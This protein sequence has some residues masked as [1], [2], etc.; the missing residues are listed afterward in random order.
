MTTFRHA[1]NG[2]MWSYGLPL[3]LP[4]LRSCSPRTALRVRYWS[5]SRALACERWIQIS[6][7]QLW[8][9]CRMPRTSRLISKAPWPRICHSPSVF[10]GLMNPHT[11]AHSPGTPPGHHNGVGPCGIGR[12]VLANASSVVLS[13]CWSSPLLFRNAAPLKS[14]API[15][16]C[17]GHITVR[18]ANNTFS[19]FRVSWHNGC[20]C[21]ATS[22]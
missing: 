3:F 22:W 1:V 19:R 12:L 16:T 6:W 15:S 7:W 21:G 10:G 2:H 17:S 13:R 4:C 9:V 18:T 20:Q 14:P 8:S 5:T 11:S